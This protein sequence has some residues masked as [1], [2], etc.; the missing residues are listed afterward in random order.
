MYWT[1]RVKNVNISI[2]GVVSSWN[3]NNSANKYQVL[4]F[5]SLNL[6]LAVHEVKIT[7]NSTTN[8][9]SIDAIDIDDTGYLI[10]PSLTAPTNLTATTDN[11]KVDLNWSAVTGA[12]SYNVK[13]ATTP[14]GPYNIIATNVTGVTY[15]DINA[16]IGST[17]YYVVTAINANGQSA[18][19][20]IASVTLQIKPQYRAILTIYLTNGTEKEYDL[21]S[22][23]IDAFVDWY[24]NKDS[25]IGPAKYAFKKAWNKGPFSKR[26]EC[27]IF[28]KILTFNVDE[29]AAEE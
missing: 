24:D 22:T 11:T 1:N 16:T 19:S 25:G 12:A 6:P 20:N 9:F 7:T 2:D 18:D 17:Y 14:G 8:N 10:N 15:S 26:T 23:E 5:E 4:V 28:D 21:T 3:P 27:V 29:Y 13:R